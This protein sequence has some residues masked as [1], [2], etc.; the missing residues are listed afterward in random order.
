MDKE[1]ITMQQSKIICLAKIR[2]L[3]GKVVAM[4]NDFYAIPVS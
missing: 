2:K 4:I 3:L 1:M